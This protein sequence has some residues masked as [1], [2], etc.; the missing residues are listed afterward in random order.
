MQC[1]TWLGLN[2]VSGDGIVF[3]IIVAEE[4]LKKFVSL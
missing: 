2:L 1:L 4:I 3:K